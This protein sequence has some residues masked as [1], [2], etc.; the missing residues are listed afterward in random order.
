MELR[1]AN[2][3]D[4]PQIVDLLKKSLGETR[5][6][7]SIQLW[8]W[9]HYENVSGKSEILLAFEGGN[10][11]GVRPF[12]KWNWKLNSKII[13]SLRAVDTAVHPDFQGKG[14]FRIL[15]L[16]LI[17]QVGM[18]YAFIFNTPNKKSKPG[19]LRMGWQSAGRIS[20]RI[21]VNRR[22]FGRGLSFD[23][24]N[25]REEFS[26]QRV[27]KQITSGFK[28]ECNNNDNCLIPS[29]TEE[30]IKWRYA[31]CPI[32][33]Y[34]AIGDFSEPNSFLLIFRLTNT[35]GMKELRILEFLL[36]PNFSANKEIDLKV[37]NLLTAL[38]PNLITFANVYQLAKI[39][40]S[41]KLMNQAINLTFG[42]VITINK[43]NFISGE[44][45]PGRNWF[46]A[47]GDLEL[48]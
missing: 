36:H 15:T 43:L 20:L 22:S 46:P 38:K 23:Q 4:A 47:L 24:L 21:I 5:I 31:N 42:P 16:E 6:K 27:L 28:L 17:K 10:L 33:N 41:S 35:F 12:M 19:Y 25:S 34:N 39:R 14:I 7:K 26:I 37:N 44:I 45:L 40:N 32:H 18:N 2:P 30:F 29:R 1:K 11:V 3:T 13:N 9:K 8:N 48:F